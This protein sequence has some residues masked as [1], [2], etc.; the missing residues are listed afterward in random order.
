[1]TTPAELIAAAVEGA[2]AVDHA[3]AYRPS[4]LDG[5]MAFVTPSEVWK[6]TD[7][8]EPTFGGYCGIS[9]GL[10]VYLIAPSSDQLQ[11]QTWLDEQSTILMRLA[12]IDVGDDVVTAGPVDAPFVFSTG[13][14][15]S[16]FAVRVT[17]SRFTIGD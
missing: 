7:E 4:R 15:S 17:Y 12:P 6:S 1:M 10:D 3:L 13:D 11:A 14:G 8:D 16:F 2:C 5:K 9:V